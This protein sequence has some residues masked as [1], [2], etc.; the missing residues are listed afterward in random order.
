MKYFLL[1]I[2]IAL[3]LGG[4]YGYNTLATAQQAKVDADQQQITKLQKDNTSLTDD[5]A[6]LAKSASD[7]Q[8]QVTDLTTQLQ[9]AQTSLTATQ[10]KLDA[11]QKSLA[12]DEAKIA[13]AAAAAAAAKVAATVPADP[14]SLGTITTLDGKT[15]QNC[16]LL[17]IDADGITINH[18]EGI[19]KIMFALLPMELQKKFGYQPGSLTTAH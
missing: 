17:K 8:A 18:S 3:C 4:Y 5:K 10:S 12:D 13:K 14:N 6:K 19:T 11:A 2:I 16:D 7:A 15:Y 9:T 1:F